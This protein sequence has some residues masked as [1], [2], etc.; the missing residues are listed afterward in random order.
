MIQIRQSVS[1]WCF[2]NRGVEDA[3][4]LFQIAKIGFEAVELIS[5]DKFPLVQDAGLKIASHGGH[6]SIE[7]GLNDLR[8]HDRIEREIK[9]KLELAQEYQIP[10]LIVFSGNRRADLTDA[11]G[12]RNTAQGLCRVA[13]AAE[14]AGVTL[15][16]ELLNS[17]IDHPGYQCDCTAWGVQV[18]EQ[19]GSPRVKLLYD[20]HHMQIMEG[21]LIRTIQTHHSQFCHYHTAGNPGRHDLDGAQEINY[22]AVIAA[23]RATGYD[24]YVGHEFLPKGDPVKALE[25]AYKSCDV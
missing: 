16:M 18:C 4:L 3:A 14:D 23:V 1:W 9:Q 15:A 6:V 21:D 11:D 25:Q 13:Q 8:E 10:N 12:I 2:E 19:V 5:E 17:K 20:I 7:H 22:P 24:G